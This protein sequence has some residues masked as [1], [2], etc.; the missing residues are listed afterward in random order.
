[1]SKLFIESFNVQLASPHWN[2]FEVKYYGV[3]SSICPSFII[4]RYPPSGIWL[5]SIS[6]NFY[7]TI[8]ASNLA[9]YISLTPLCKLLNFPLSSHNLVPRSITFKAGI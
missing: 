3:S 6:D 5:I 4:V 1:M 2:L 7:E 9:M 8:N